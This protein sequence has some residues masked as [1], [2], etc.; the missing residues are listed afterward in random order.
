MAMQLLQGIIKQLKSEP[1]T[2]KD[3]DDEQ[4]IDVSD[5]KIRKNYQ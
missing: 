4:V 5:N 3:V 1:S 2:F